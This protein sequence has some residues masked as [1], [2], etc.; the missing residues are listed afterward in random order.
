MRKLNLDPDALEIQSFPTTDAEEARGTVH[1][2]ATQDVDSC[3]SCDCS[4]MDTC[5]QPQITCYQSC[6]GSC[7]SCPATCTCPSSDGRC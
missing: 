7:Q 6:A 5:P 2:M 3:P 4:Y 1:G